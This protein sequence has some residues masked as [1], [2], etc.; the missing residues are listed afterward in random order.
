MDLPQKRY[1]GFSPR[2]IYNL[3]KYAIYCLLLLNTYLFL[4]EELAA[5]DHIFNG[6]LSFENIIISFSTTIDT[7]AWVVLLLMFELETYV[8]PD[9]KL[10]GKMK[11]ALHLFRAICYLFIFQAFFGYAG[12]ALGTHGFNLTD[13]TSA[14]NAI[15]WSYM[16]DLDEFITITAA[17][18]QDLSK[19]SIMQLAG[20]DI[21]SSPDI[22]TASKW[23]AWV[24]VVNAA[25]WILIVLILEADVWVQ[26]RQGF[27][28]KWMTINKWVKSILYSILLLAAMYWGVLGSFLDFWDAFLWLVAFVF[29]EMNIFEWQDEIK[30]EQMEASDSQ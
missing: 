10:Q 5:A 14:C 25:V 8:I 3:F 29:I 20:K 22:V 19:G 6:S 1:M 17:N 11:W 9:N 2:D 18:C 13:L 24:D 15:G 28:S 21:I 12:K 23:L 7:A 4:M 30:T 26:T 16:T 27:D